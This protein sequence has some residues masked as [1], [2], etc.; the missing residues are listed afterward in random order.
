MDSGRRR[1]S[2]AVL[3]IKTADAEHRLWHAAR[4]TQAA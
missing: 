3:G 4:F 2:A 1:R